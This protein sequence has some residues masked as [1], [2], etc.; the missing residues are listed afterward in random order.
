MSDMCTC[1]RVVEQRMAH[2]PCAA[3]WNN[4]SL[5]HLMLCCAQL[6]MPAPQH[7]ICRVPFAG[8]GRMGDVAASLCKY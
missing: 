8:V 1:P 5:E 3:T 7:A 2:V 4:L 6:T